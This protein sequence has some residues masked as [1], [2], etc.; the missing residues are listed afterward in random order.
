M[1]ATVVLAGI[2]HSTKPIILSLKMLS[3]R[4]AGGG[5]TQTNHPVIINV[6]RA[7]VVNVVEKKKKR[8]LVTL[9][10]EVRNNFTEDM[11]QLGSWTI[12]EYFHCERWRK[13]K[14]RAAGSKGSH[15]EKETYEAPWRTEHIIHL[16]IEGFFGWGNGG[17]MV[18]KYKTR[19]ICALSFRKYLSS[20]REF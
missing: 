20:V 19:K 6:I 18:S 11:T 7:T 5:G 2:K 12:D 3:S 10:G 17:T 15:E 14:L 16:G 9:T 8:G 1:S 13:F 4:G